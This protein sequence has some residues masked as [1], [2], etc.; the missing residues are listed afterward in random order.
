MARFGFIAQ[1]QDISAPSQKISER[2]RKL[3][4]TENL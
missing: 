1:A 3:W 4:Y 2:A